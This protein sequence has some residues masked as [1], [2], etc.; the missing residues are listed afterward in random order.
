MPAEAEFDVGIETQFLVEDFG[1]IVGE[2]VGERRGVHN[3]HGAPHFGGKPLLVFLDVREVGDGDGVVVLK[4][5]GV[6]T[7]E[8]GVAGREGEIGFSVDGV[9]HVG[10]CAQTVVI[11]DE[12][13]ARHVKPVEF[14]LHPFEF[15]GETEVGH[16][17]AVDDEVD[18][19]LG[20]DASDGGGRFIVPALGVADDGKTQ[21]VAAV[22]FFF[23]GGNGFGVKLSGAAVSGVVG[24]V[25]DE[26]ATAGGDKQAG[27]H[28]TVSQDGFHVAN[29][30]ISSS[31]GKVCFSYL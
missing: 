23:D 31:S 29:I 5:I 1:N 17:A 13:D 12:A 7:D 8:M 9:I 27:Q 3:G 20:V 24:V 19:A 30:V 28:T 14:A 6:E 2:L 15:A 21:T 16:V 26:V 25:V 22:A 4:G 10:T 11:A 18:V